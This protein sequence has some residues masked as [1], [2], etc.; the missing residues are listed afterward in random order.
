LRHRESRYVAERDKGTER[1]R[2]A[3]A[4]LDEL[5]RRASEGTVVREDVDAA[6]AEALG[7]QR[8]IFGPRPRA[9]KGEGG[10]P[11]IL[12]Y[13]Q[14]HVGEEVSGEELRAAAGFIG[15]WA[16]R[17]RELDVEQGYDIDELGGS[18]YRLN[19]VEP[20]VAR[21]AEWQL[22]NSIRNSGGSG[23]DRVG[24]LLEAKVGEVVD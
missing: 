20:D 22:L 8:Q 17:V 2:A 13:L 1:L 24:K 3:A 5:A 6:L 16:R 21:A 19:S 23:R 9:K 11:R 18:V 7:A 12:A 15:E 14:E 10:G 4:H